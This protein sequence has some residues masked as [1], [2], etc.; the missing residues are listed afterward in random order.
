M[1][2][3]LDTH[4]ALALVHREMS[5]YGASIE[6]LVQAPEHDRVV[7]AATLWE[8]AIK[9]RLGKLALRLPLKAIPDFLT[10]LGVTLLAI[11][12]RHAV[13]DLKVSP[14]TRDPFDKLLLAQCQVDGMRLVTADRALVSHPLSW[15]P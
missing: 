8:T 3:L 4:I 6:T 5:R 13:E 11:D 15:Q 14:H 10:A 12:Q 1:K 9:H 7:S 2:L